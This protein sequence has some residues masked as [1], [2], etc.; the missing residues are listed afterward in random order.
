MKEKK[1][2]FMF[3]KGLLYIVYKILYN[4]KVEGREN[5]IEEGP[6]VYC[7]N[8]VHILDQCSIIF[9]TKRMIHYMAK[10]EYFDGPFSW[11]FKACGCISVDRSIHDGDAK[12]KALEVLNN[13][14]ALGIFPEG[15]RNMIHCKEDRTKELYKHYED[16]YTLKE[17]KKILKKN[18]ARVSQIDFMKELVESKKITEKEFID[19]CMDPN[20]FLKKL[21]KKKKI[22]E[23]EYYDTLFLPLKYGAVSFAQKT[24][25]YIVPFVTRGTYKMF[26]KDFV[27][28]IGKPFK[29]GKM[30]LEQANNKL[31]KELID[32]IK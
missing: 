14:Q 1:G 20:S 18:F 19:N 29:V 25:A 24:D 3:V 13:N 27:I 7:G 2:S 21:V 17:F 15:T 31:R 5:V 9:P 8:H 4:P 32:L 22:K 10:K 12:K 30:T 16:K 28:A 11:F 6:V 26:S 23:N